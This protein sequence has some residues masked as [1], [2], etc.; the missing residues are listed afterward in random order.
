MIVTTCGFLVADL[1]AADMPKLASPGELVFAPE[2]IQLHVGGHPANVAIDLRQLGLP[3]R[4]VSVIGAV[5]KDILGDFI[6]KTLI[7]HGVITHLKKLS[8]GTT[9]DIILVLKG[10]DRRCHLD[11]GAS[12]NLDP[13]YIKSVVKKEK[14]Y[15]FYIATGI[16][17]ELDEEL[18]EVLETIKDYNCL[19]FVDIVQP[20]GKN[21]DFILP[22]L[23]QTDIFHC[24]NL[25]LLSITK[26]NRKSEAL[27]SLAEHG[28]KLIL[29]SLGSEGIMVGRKGVRPIR[30]KAFDVQVVDPTGSGDALCAGIIYELVQNEN[31]K[32]LGKDKEVTRISP[33]QLSKILLTGQAAGAACVTAVG[34]TTAVI[35]YNV[36]KLIEKQ[37]PRILSSTKI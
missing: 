31:M 13:N 4:Q 25:E 33:K 14:P 16:E 1:I 34:T 28:V 2:G 20:F 11:L 17:K 10:E 15:L 19:T 32:L 36:R 18:P 12:W 26:K 8:Q 9:K 6:S 37:A 22:A 3:Q 35:S 5:G 27:E 7:D 24:N 21:W 23:E 29:V 30:Q